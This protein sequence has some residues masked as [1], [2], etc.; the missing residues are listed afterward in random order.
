MAS[1]RAAGGSIGSPGATVLSIPPDNDP[2]RTAWSR[3]DCLW[4]AA[5]RQ[6]V[7]TTF[8]RLNPVFDLE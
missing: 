1:I 2:K 3:H 7:D 4:L 8:A 6:I 5:K